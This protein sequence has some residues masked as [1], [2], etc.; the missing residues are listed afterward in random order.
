MKDISWIFE[1]GKRDSASSENHCTCCGSLI[2]D[3]ERTH[4]AFLRCGEYCPNNRRAE[5]IKHS[6]SYTCSK[7]DSVICFSCK[8]KTWNNFP[9]CPR[10]GS[11]MVVHDWDWVFNDG[12]FISELKIYREFIEDF[13][14]PGYYIG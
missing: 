1:N 7:N 10:C 3:F 14:K 9:N 13:R 5:I 12:K 11:S 6:P 4:A 8:N 2:N